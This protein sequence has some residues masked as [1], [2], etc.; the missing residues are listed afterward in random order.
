[1]SDFCLTDFKLVL[2]SCFIFQT[3]RQ[4]KFAQNRNYTHAHSLSKQFSSCAMGFTP[5][6][7]RNCQEDVITSQSGADKIPKLFNHRPKWVCNG[8]NYQ[9]SEENSRFAYGAKPKP[10]KRVYSEG[11]FPPLDLPTGLKKLEIKF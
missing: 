2:V 10:V 8:I 5:Y 11:K 6:L 4:R 1:M 9:S 3:L 7:A